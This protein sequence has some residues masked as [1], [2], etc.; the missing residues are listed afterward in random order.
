MPE[1][2]QIWRRVVFGCGTCMDCSQAR[3]LDFEVRS[4][5]ARCLEGKG[6]WDYGYAGNGH[7]HMGF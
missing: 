1:G 2:M 5:S 7:I 4:I 6:L 3:R